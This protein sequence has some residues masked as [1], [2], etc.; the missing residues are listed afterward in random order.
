MKESQHF[1]HTDTLTLVQNCSWAT[2]LHYGEENCWHNKCTLWLY[3]SLKPWCLRLIWWNSGIRD[4]CE[5]SRHK[6]K[7]HEESAAALTTITSG[8]LLQCSPVLLLNDITMP[9]PHIPPP[10]V[11]TSN[12]SALCWVEKEGKKGTCQHCRMQRGEQGEKQEMTGE[13]GGILEMWKGIT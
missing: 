10:E 2:V 3:F 8:R 1:L 9:L 12:K 13:G 5:V 7:Q 4:I 6:G 11:E